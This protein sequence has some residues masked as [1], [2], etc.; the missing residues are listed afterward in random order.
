MNRAETRPL[1]RFETALTLTGEHAPFVVVIVLRFAGGP[2]APSRRELRTALD[3]LQRRE[4]ML[5]VRIV[6]SSG[7]RPR[8]RFDSEGV[9]GIPLRPVSRKDHTTWRAEA[10][11][12]LNED[13]DTEAGPLVR[14][15]HVASGPVADASREASCEVLLTFHH[16]AVD[17]V[18]GA[19]LV[20]RLLELLEASPDEASPNLSAGDAGPAR[21]EPVRPE[22]ESPETE[23]LFPVVEERFPAAYRGLR[24]AGKLLGFLARQVADEMQV[25][26]RLRRARA[27]GLRQPPI[28]EPT[29]CR[30][31]PVE[32]SA[33]ASEALVRAL[34]RRRIT[35]NAA[36]N[37]ALL[38]AVHRHLYE[39]R[40]RPLRYITFADLR[41]YLRPP[42]SED[43]LGCAIT[44]LR[45]T[46]Q[47]EED[48]RF[49]PLADTISRQVD[50]GVRRGDRFHSVRMSEPLMRTILERRTERM[51]ATAVSYSGVARFGDRD[52]LLGSHAFVSN[53]GLGP[54]YTTLA[55]WFRDRLQLDILYLETD[56]DETR[57]Q[58]LAD[59]ILRTLERAG[60]EAT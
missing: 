57:A 59:D 30:I 37:A 49:W 48:G 4:P 60:E 1:G 14:C 27:R 18:S 20:E 51:A 7:R 10:E 25:R 34:R 26:W 35:V 6:S 46:A 31:L 53:L 32:L 2:G 8:Y 42:I 12:E 47:L 56:L 29:R 21:R 28:V 39:G 19:A 43:R 15:A 58:G 36:L 40:A 16:T 13:L 55:R 17:A 22:P 45:Y 38:L 44:M 23:A 54:E 33:D 24:G 52:R 3:T 50:A 41:P 11:R 9:P 5:Q